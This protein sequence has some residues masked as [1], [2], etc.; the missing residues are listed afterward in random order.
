MSSRAW[1]VDLIRSI[2]EK[3]TLADHLEELLLDENTPERQQM[4]TNLLA[5]RREQMNTLL[6]QAEHPDPKYWC[7]FKHAVKSYTL[8]CEVFEA[9]PTETN[10][11]AL[12]ASSEVLAGITSLF[13]GMEFET[14]ARCLYDQL[15]VKQYDKIKTTNKGERA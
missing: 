15:L 14:C 4:L 9:E 8:D 10:F 13:L 5:L 3:T 7:P 6:D 11:N 2:G 1:V 12:K